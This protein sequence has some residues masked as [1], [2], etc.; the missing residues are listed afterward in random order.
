MPFHQALHT[1]AL[2][3][4]ICMHVNTYDDDEDDAED[5]IVPVKPTSTGVFEGIHYITQ[6]RH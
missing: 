2:T 1:H 5:I 4:T 3:P 6:D